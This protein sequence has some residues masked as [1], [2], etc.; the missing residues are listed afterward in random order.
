MNRFIICI[1]LFLC[2]DS[3]TA[4]DDLNKLNRQAEQGNNE[5]IMLLGE[6]Y[7]TGINVE[8]NYPKAFSYFKMAADNDN[9][10]AMYYLFQCYTFGRGVEENLE[11]AGLWLRKAAI[12]GNDDAFNEYIA[13]NP[14]EKEIILGLRKKWVEEHIEKKVRNNTQIDKTNLEFNVN[15]VSFTMVFVEGG[16]FDMG[17]GNEELNDL[18]KNGIIPYERKSLD[19]TLLFSQQHNVVLSN[20]YIGQTEVTQELWYTV[21]GS[22]PSFRNFLLDERRKKYPVENISWDDCQIF[23]KRLNELTGQTFRLPTEAEWEYAAKGG[24]KSNGY[25]YSGSNKLN[26]VAWVRQKKRYPTS[27]PVAK[28]KP[29]ELGIYDMTG[30]VNEWCHDFWGYYGNEKQNN[31]Q[32]PSHG[33]SHIYRGGGVATFFEYEYFLWYR[34]YAKSDH[35]WDFSGVRL[36]L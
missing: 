16:S 20:Y 4:Q 8:K 9:S 7:Y 36:A 33:V 25:K 22:N 17:L 28:K 35:Q 27:H 31:P 2:F 12:A 5:A 32:G 29:N 23:I 10:K 13:R 1:L 30:N 18:I 6:F 24:K 19:N 26:K 34:H 3:V 15:G 11:K 14:N 21:M